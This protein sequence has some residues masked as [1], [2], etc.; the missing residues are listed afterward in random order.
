MPWERTEPMSERLLFVS[1][2]REKLYSMTELCTRFGIS[3][4]IGYKWLARFEAEGTTGLDER[5][6]AP[7]SSPRRTPPAVEEVL[8]AAKR[9]HPHWGPAKIKASLERLRPGEKFPAASTIGE[10][11]KRHGAVTPRKTRSRSSHPGTPPLEVAAPNE[12]WATDFK[13]DFRLGNRSRCYPLTVSDSYSRVLLGC[14][15]LPS[16]ATPGVQT[17]FEALFSEFGLPEAIRSD[18][19]IPFVASQAPLGLSRLTLWW[20]KL[21]IAHH[22][23]RPG[24]P[25]ENGRLERLHRT[26]KAEATRPPEDDLRAQQERFDRFRAE[27]NRERPHAALGQVPPASCY[28]TSPRVM[29][30]R[31]AAPEYPGH[32]EVRRVNKAGCFHF[33]GEHPFL[34]EV[35]E[36]EDVGL[37]EEAEGV[38]SVYFYRQLVA[39]YD[40]RRKRT[41]G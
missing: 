11:F 20:I 16:T 6:R 37:V 1:L 8:M 38:W 10:V 35:L 31:L 30:A 27:Y 26:L 15:A 33:R 2:Y 14:T 36:G 25:S 39:R 17:A 7:H 23:I 18:N 29:P 22:R 13:G 3:R 41:F 4:R 5:S 32:Y 40:V 24:K 34:T 9:A 19:G 12:V 28:S 21:G